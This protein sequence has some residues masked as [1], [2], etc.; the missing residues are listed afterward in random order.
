[1]DYEVIRSG[2]KTI[3]IEINR[4]RVIVRAPFNMTDRYIVKYL[5]RKEDKIKKLLAKDAKKW[6]KVKGLDLYTEEE[7][8]KIKEKA[9]AVIPER[10]KFYADKMGVTYNKVTVRCQRTLWGSCSSQG[11][12]SFNCLLV[13]MPD[14]VLDYVV[15]HELCHRKHMNHAILFYNELAKNYPE[16][17]KWRNWLK[18]NGIRY[19]GRLPQK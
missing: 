10:V 3:A 7:L 4:G 13:L 9:A 5:I 14:E 15:V 11:N 8:K 17:G 6:D 19:S 2:R 12:L 1:M 16:Y 18:E